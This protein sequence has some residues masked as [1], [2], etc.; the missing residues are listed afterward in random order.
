MKQKLMMMVWNIDLDKGGMTRVMLNRSSLLSDEYDSFLVTLDFNIKYESIREKLVEMKRLDPRV[1]L[2]NP[3][4]Y[5]RKLF[6]KSDVTRKQKYDYRKKAELKVKGYEMQDDEF[7]EKKYIRY[8]KDGLYV[9]YKKWNSS[10]D[11]I[12]IDYFNSNRHRTYREEFLENGML[13]RKIYF[14]LNTNKSKQEVYYTNDGEWYLN[15]WINPENGNIQNVFLRNPRENKLLSFP[16]N[17]KFHTHWINTICEQESIKPIM[18]CD[19]PGSAKK[20]LD[21]DSNLVYKMFTIHSNHF[22][23][24][25]TVGSPIKSNHT[26]ILKNI[27]KEDALI[28]LTDTQKQHIQDQFGNHDNIFV[29]PNY[30]DPSPIESKGQNKNVISII[31]RLHSEKRIDLAIKAFS[32][33]VKTETTIKLEI[34]GSGPDKDRLEK[35]I[36]ELKMEDKIFLMG[37]AS[38]VN[39]IYSKSLFTVLTSAYEGFSLAIIESMTNGTPVLA[40]DVLYSPSVIIEDG[41]S[42][43]LVEDGDIEELAKRMSYLLENPEVAL[44][45]GKY[46]KQSVQA[47]FGPSKHKEMWLELL[48]NFQ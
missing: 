17:G 40:F 9:F 12:Y 6:S 36:K 38:N 29:I 31:S 42:G 21:A 16:N 39:E 19:G 47:R 22:S 23:S 44:E 32:K 34:H 14:D 48:K 41:K 4:E 25:H 33:A 26:D 20:L 45:M 10:G 7:E 8:F 24:P 46:A 2:L 27:A 37:Y 13:Y 5:Y 11:L 30:V 43:Y 3:Y 18:I 15:K 28:L 1:G 35:L